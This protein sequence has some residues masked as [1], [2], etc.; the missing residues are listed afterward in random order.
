MT[1][2]DSSGRPR[3]GAMSAMVRLMNKFEQLPGDHVT[4][5]RQMVADLC[6]LLS[7]QVGKP[8]APELPP[9][10]SPRLGQTLTRLLLGDGEKQIATQLGLSRHTVHVYVKALYKHF[11]V[12]SRGELL[13]RFVRSA[14]VAPGAHTAIAADEQGTASQLFKLRRLPIE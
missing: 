13:A 10:L 8:Q 14:D 12:C 4:R 5:K 6:R 3:V 9:G 1:V 2:S 11:D 7:A